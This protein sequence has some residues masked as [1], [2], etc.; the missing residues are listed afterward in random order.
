MRFAHLTPLVASLL[1]I[2]VYSVERTAT[3]V[4]AAEK[5]AANN[6]L[7]AEQNAALAAI[8]IRL[9]A[10][11]AVAAK[12]DDSDYMAEVARQIQD[13]KDR[14]RALEK[15]FD[16]A[17][18]E[19]LMHSVISRYQVAG[20]WLKAPPL[21]APDPNTLTAEEVAAGWRLL[22]DGKS[23]AG[24]RGYRAKPLPESWKV[25]NGS[26]L[27][28]RAAGVSSGDII[29]ADQFDDFEL[30]VDWK[31]TKGNNS[32]IIYRATEEHDQVW[33][34]GPEYQVLDNSGHLDGL[35]A[36]ASAG[37]CYAVF[38]PTKDMTRPLG[39]WNTARIVAEGKHVEHWLNGAKVVEYDVDSDIWKAHVK[40]SK[41]F[42]TTYGQGNWGRAKRG[43]IG[44]QDYGGAIEF[45][46]IKVRSPATGSKRE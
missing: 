10:L 1:A 30:L 46:N 42:P 11:L 4:V 26:L 37:A 14:R 9:S 33:Q 31:M 29:T 12:I 19:A 28:R 24:W 45:R 21:P 6:A 3:T 44:L 16:Q 5:P 13:L 41:F 23:L 20:L 39:E 15:N 8:D 40:T 43:H 34:S 2:G 32:G 27:S 25:E 36:F 7:T 22:F 18:Y 35:N 38:A 17:L